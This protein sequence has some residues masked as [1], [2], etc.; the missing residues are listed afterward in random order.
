MKLSPRLRVSAAVVL[1]LLA[2]CLISGMRFVPWNTATS[3]DPLS[4]LLVLRLE[5]DQITGH[6][7]GDAI[8]SWPD[9][10]TGNTP[11]LQASG[12]SQPAW[13]AVDANFNSHPSMDFSASGIGMDTACN[14]TN[15]FTVVIVARATTAASS[16][17]LQSVDNNCVL[18]FDRSSDAV[19]N[20]GDVVSSTSSVGTAPHIISL[21]IGAESR[22][23]IDGVDVTTGTGHLAD[24]GRLAIGRSAQGG[25]EDGNAFIAAIGAFN[26][27]NDTTRQL[28]EATWK[29]KYGTP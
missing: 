22:C 12:A 27:V 4:G 20:G 29:A 2:P 25:G 9:I 18:G 3:G 5:A 6:A 14:L 26:S 21:A 13:K 11:G 17:T 28:I 7:D 16:R 1:L 8:S 23:Y 15:A 24:W 10:G 19:Y